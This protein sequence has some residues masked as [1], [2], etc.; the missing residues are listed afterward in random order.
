[1]LYNNSNIKWLHKPSAIQSDDK[2]LHDDFVRLP[3]VCLHQ[4]LLGVEAY[5]H[6]ET[7]IH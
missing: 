1:M 7:L 3:L 5:N 6:D 2:L 4:P